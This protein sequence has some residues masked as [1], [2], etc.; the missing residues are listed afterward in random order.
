MARWKSASDKRAVLAETLEFL[1]AIATLDVRLCVTERTDNAKY[2]TSL[3][4]ENY[5][6]ME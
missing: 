3:L 6:A 1:W 5:L 4:P 2:A